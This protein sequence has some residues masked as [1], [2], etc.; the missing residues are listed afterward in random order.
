[1][2]LLFHK[3]TIFDFFFFARSTRAQVDLYCVWMNKF[4]MA[5]NHRNSMVN[6]YADDA[7]VQ[8]RGFHT[9]CGKISKLKTVAKKST[10]KRDMYY[11]AHFCFGISCFA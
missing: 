9:K 11:G 3:E 10:N 8:N 6:T 4:A 7:Y 1:M 2:R 5:T